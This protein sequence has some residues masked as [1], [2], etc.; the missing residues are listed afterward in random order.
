MLKL[1]N[2]LKKQHVQNKA[3]SK[4]YISFRENWGVEVLSLVVMGIVYELVSR[5]GK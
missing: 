3:G 4:F 1:N 2:V 5:G